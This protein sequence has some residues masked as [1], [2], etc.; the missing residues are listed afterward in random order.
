M[1]CIVVMW[2][3]THVT[4]GFAVLFGADAIFKGEKYIFVLIDCWL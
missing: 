4:V 2:N 1:R 3:D